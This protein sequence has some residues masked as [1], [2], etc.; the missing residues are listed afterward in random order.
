MK[1]R[2]VNIEQEENNLA[3]NTEDNQHEI[4]TKLETSL[5]KEEVEARAKLREELSE[6]V[7][8]VYDKAISSLDDIRERNSVRMSVN[9]TDGDEYSYKV[10]VKQ[11]MN[12]EA[13]IAVY[14]EYYMMIVGPS[15]RGDCFT[16]YYVGDECDIEYGADYEER[17]NSDIGSP[18][19]SVTCKSEK[20]LNINSI[21]KSFTEV[22]SGSEADTGGWNWSDTVVEHITNPDGSKVDRI[23]N[24]YDPYMPARIVEAKYDKNDQLIKLTYPYV[25]GFIEID[26]LEFDKVYDIKLP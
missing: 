8:L 14:S 15:C 10:D 24:K 17:D 26:F 11:E 12:R 4:N 21:G 23:V 3:E 19:G 7:R 5:S 2:D 16:L 18:V 6:D 1:T 9:L 13:M 25:I 20:A 22:M